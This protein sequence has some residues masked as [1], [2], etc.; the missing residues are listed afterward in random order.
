MKNNPLYFRVIHRTFQVTILLIALGLGIGAGYV[1]YSVTKEDPYPAVIVEEATYFVDINGELVYKVRRGDI[2]YFDKE[3]CIS[4]TDPQALVDKLLSGQIGHNDTTRD[5]TEA[6]QVTRGSIKG[7]SRGHFSDGIVVLLP[8]REFIIGE[9][10]YR[11]R[12]SVRIPEALSTGPNKLQFNFIYQINT[13]KS[14]FNLDGPSRYSEE[15]KFE[16]VK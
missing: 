5:L 14:A 12:N 8:D 6:D 1:S 2:V 7:I 13:I 3:F 10:C 11:V 4:L 16:V 15:I 9:G